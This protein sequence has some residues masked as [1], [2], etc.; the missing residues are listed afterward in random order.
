MASSW[1][2]IYLSRVGY[3]RASTHIN[4]N[5]SISISIRACICIGIGCIGIGIGF[6]FCI[7]YII[8]RCIDIGCFMGPGLAEFGPT[9]S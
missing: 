8:T 9:D 2:S 1:L 7:D 4:I 6:C 3:I 5:I